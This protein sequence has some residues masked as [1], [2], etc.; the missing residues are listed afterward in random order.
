MRDKYPSAT[1]GTP[2]ASPLMVITQSKTTTEPIDEFGRRLGEYLVGKEKLP[3]RSLEQTLR[4]W[5]P[6]EEAYGVL[7]VRLGLVSERDIA[8]AVAH[9][10]DAPLVRRED[11]PSM[12]LFEQELP[13]SFLKEAK[14]IPLADG[15]DAVMVAMAAPEDRFTRDALHMALGKPVTVRAGTQSEIMEAIERLYGGNQSEMLQISEGIGERQT[16]DDDSVERLKDLASEAPIVRLVNLII[17]QA[18]E[19]R[20]SDIHIE[21]FGH[22]LQI[23]FRIDGELTEIEAPPVHSTAAVISRIKLI[24]KLN[25][26]ERRL[27]QDGRIP[28]RIQGKD[29]DIRVSTVPTLHGESVVL[30]ILDKQSVKLDFALLGFDQDTLEMFN[31]VLAVPHGIVLVTGPTGSG[32]T[33][34][35][36]TALKQLN[37]S[38]RKLLT[39]EDPIEYQLEGVNQIQTKPQ[40]GL[41]FAN[42]LRSIMRQDPDV[43]MIG[44]MR[45][46]E[47]ASIA[48]Q[49]ALTGHLVLSTLHTNNAGSSVTRLLDMGVADYLVT[50]TVR[51]ILAQRLVRQLCGECREPYMAMPELAPRLKAQGFPQVRETV[52]LFRPAGCPSCNHTGYKGRIALIELMVLSDPI[53]GMI[54]QRADG[55]EIQR[56]AKDGGMATMLMDGYRKALRGVTSIDEVM[57]VAQE[58][59]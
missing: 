53:R 18:I 15:E 44:E 24:G 47:T 27:P 13:L 56:A 46:L 9:L 36:Y 8:E 12:P 26:A 40:I 54:L 20:A 29:I 33:T 22:R 14:V 49:S 39:V 25:I 28:M 19:S 42:A 37:T 11:Y 35:L 1:L 50:S 52:E 45:D 32:K 2:I 57:R 6:E 3:E 58:V 51:A 16:D 34:T 38:N 23:R 21:P 7:L 30:R 55:S 59:I 17:N 5:V 41:T 43:I 10:T 31:E 4:L 48:V